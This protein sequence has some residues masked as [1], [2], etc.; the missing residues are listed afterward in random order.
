MTRYHE[1]SLAR[2]GKAARFVAHRTQVHFKIVVTGYSLK[3]PAAEASD[4]LTIE[5]SDK[6]SN[7]LAGIV[8][9]TGDR[10]RGE[11]L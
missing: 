2:S 3:L 6:I 5:F 9:S 11:R 4:G 1:S 10:M 7:I 8:D